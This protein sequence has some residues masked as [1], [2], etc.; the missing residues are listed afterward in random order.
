VYTGGG[1]DFWP[2][3]GH[4]IAQ[5]TFS[6]CSAQHYGSARI[7]GGAETIPSRF[8]S[9]DTSECTATSYCGGLDLQWCQSSILLSDCSFSSCKAPQEAALF[10]NSY[11]GQGAGLEKMI[12]CFFSNNV[13]SAP[14]KAHD[15]FAGS[16][17]SPHLKEHLIIF[18]YSTSTTLR[19]V[20]EG[21]GFGDKSG[22]IQNPIPTFPSGVSVDGSSETEGLC[23][24]PPYVCRT[25]SLAVAS[26]S[27]PPP[28][29]T[30]QDDDSSFSSILSSFSS[31]LSSKR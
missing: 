6:K 13:A 24:S 10:F 20:L 12:F 22:W 21:E 31:F 1:I 18:C 8:I 26:L 16:T 25:I 27:L 28:T 5:C 30:E 29:T 23:L 4:L 11:S 19:R 2:S 14:I 7:A 3:S 17:F 9:C 15:I